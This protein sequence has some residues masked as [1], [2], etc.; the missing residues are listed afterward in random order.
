MI[1]GQLGGRAGQ[2]ELAPSKDWLMPGDSK[3]LA[4]EHTFHMQTNQSK[5]YTPT[6]SF[7]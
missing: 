4:C 7:I 2:G 3:L 5:A 6:T 1:L